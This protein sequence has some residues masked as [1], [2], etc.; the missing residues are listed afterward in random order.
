MSIEDFRQLGRKYRDA[1][2]ELRDLNASI[3]EK[4]KVKAEFEKQIVEYL[5]KPEFENFKQLHI[6]D[7]GTLFNVKRPNTWTK[8]WSM[9]K[10]D[11][12]DYLRNY[13]TSSV[14]PNAEECFQFV[15]E[16]RKENSVG[17]EFLIERSARIIQ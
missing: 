8:P 2:N 7:D 9:S 13:F 5:Q 11:L 4:R 14:Q 3:V 1:D 12:I 15:C 17:K 6:S 16:A 10:T